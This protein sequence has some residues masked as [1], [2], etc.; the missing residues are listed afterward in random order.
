MAFELFESMAW[1]P[2]LTFLVPTFAEEP[3]FPLFTDVALLVAETPLLPEAA[4][5]AEVARFALLA[6]SLLSLSLVIAAAC[7]KV[8]FASIAMSSASWRVS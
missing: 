2:T 8:R 1:P 5:L 3:D 7:A 6:Y 4:L